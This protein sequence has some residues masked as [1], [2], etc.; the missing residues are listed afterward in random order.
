MGE[1][2]CTNSCRPLDAPAELLALSHVVERDP[3]VVSSNSY[4]FLVRMPCAAIDGVVAALQDPE[5]GLFRHRCGLG[6]VGQ[7]FVVVLKPFQKLGLAGGKTLASELKRVLQPAR[8]RPI[9]KNTAYSIQQSLAVPR[10]QP[11]SSAR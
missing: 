1:R 7:P 8:A 10:V 3:A 11:G 5:L 6:R 2:Y 9:A 4:C